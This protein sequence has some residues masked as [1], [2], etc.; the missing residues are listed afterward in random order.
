MKKTSAVGFLKTEPRD[1]P[2]TNFIRIFLTMQIA[3]KKS[4]TPNRREN[5]YGMAIPKYPKYIP[6]TDA[7]NEA[8]K[9]FMNPGPRL[10][11]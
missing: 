5:L 2:A 4:N 1:P 7:P 10:W 11:S 8:Q 6:Q 9:M 3:M